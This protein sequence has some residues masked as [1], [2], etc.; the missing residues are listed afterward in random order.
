MRDEYEQ[1]ARK[2]VDELAKLDPDLV[3]DREEAVKELTAALPKV[4]AVCGPPGSMR[5][6][7]IW[8]LV[9]APFTARLHGVEVER[10]LWPW[11]LILLRAFGAVAGPIFGLIQWVGFWNLSR[12]G[13]DANLSDAGVEVFSKRKGH[14]ATYA[15]TEIAQMRRIFEPPITFW[16]LVLTSGQEVALPLAELDARDFRAHGIIVHEADRFR[17]EYKNDG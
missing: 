9:K 3:V 11:G 2:L 4:E 16:E 17:S 15:W 5:G 7:S 10:G 14:I 8:E 13:C 1:Q 12:S 6:P